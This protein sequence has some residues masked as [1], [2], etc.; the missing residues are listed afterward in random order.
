MEVRPSRPAR[1]AALLAPLRRGRRS[2]LDVGLVLL[3]AAVLLTLGYGVWSSV[4]YRSGVQRGLV[5][6]L[7][8]V[9]TVLLVAALA[10]R[11]GWRRTLD[12]RTRLAW[13]VLAAALVCLGGGNA[14]SAVY[15][16]TG[17]REWIGRLAE[18]LSLLYFPAFLVGLL[19][20]PQPRRTTRE[21]L[22]FYFDAAVVAVSGAVL[23]WFYVLQPAMTTRPLDLARTLV[24]I[25]YPM[26]DLVLILGVSSLWTRRAGGA[27]PVLRFLGL[28]LFCNLIGDV[29]YAYQTQAGSFFRGSSL[30][31]LWMAGCCLIG[32]SAWWQHHEGRAAWRPRGLAGSASAAGLAAGAPAAGPPTASTSLVPLVAIGSCYTLLVLVAVELDI[33]ALTG[34]VLGG[35]ALTGIVLARQVATVRE[36]LRLQRETSARENEARFRALVQHASD[37]I[38]ILD[39]DSTVRFASPAVAR[40]FG[41]E[42][43]ELLGTR[44]IDRVHPEDMGGVLVFLDE[45]TRQAEAAVAGSW[46]MRHADG[47]WLSM[48]NSGTNLLDEPTVGGLVVNMRDVTERWALEEQLM[49]QAFHDPLTHLA[50]RALFLDRVSHALTRAPRRQYAVAVLFIDLDNFKNVN[51]S[52]GHAMGDRLLVDAAARLGRCVRQGDTIAR[53]GGDEF[54]ILVEDADHLPDIV[55]V[56]ERVTAALAQ[57]FPLDGKEVFVSASIGIASHTGE[58]STDDL[59]RNADVAMYIAKTRGKGRYEIFEPHM[60]AAALERLELEADLRRAVERSEFS[61]MYQPIVQLTNGRLVGVEALLRWDHPVRGAVEPT[62]FVPIL[63][64]T[65]LIVPVERWVLQEATRQARQWQEEAPDAEALTVT[66]NV[67]GRHLQDPTLIDDV[68]TA[69]AMTGLDPKLLVLE[70]TESM[71][72]DHDELTLQKLQRLRGWGVALAI[73]DFGT[74]YSSLSYLQRFPVDI[75]KIDKSFVDALGGRSDRPVLARAI[76]ALGDTLRLK[77]VAEGIE[78]AAQSEALKALGCGLGQG[79]FFARPLPPDEVRRELTRQTGWGP[80]KR[81]LGR[82]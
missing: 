55:Q 51:D 54:A 40:V 11:N 75:L 18:A 72:M 10:A 44:L 4:G 8:L 3:A 29:M 22:A 73:D 15:Y 61:L 5:S 17:L 60:H 33:Q 28:G 35:V 58:E 77:T 81:M 70:I 30:E 25:A 12:R 65:G 34:L 7:V 59:L 39:P 24:T 27:D 66:V 68:E 76:I 48:E 13:G 41:L 49:H 52:L 79:F 46:R 14:A 64:E 1:L 82:R 71:L 80:P 50:N 67:S 43:A 9:P 45:V 57:P 69:L 31:L 47:G 23:V 36:D 2:R 63:E 78:T 56:A 53:L 21:W 37:V 26:G 20:F 16:A 74:G 32:V 62:T 19:R 6:K 42:P 38:T